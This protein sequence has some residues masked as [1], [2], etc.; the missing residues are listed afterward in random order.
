MPSDVIPRKM[1]HTV[2]GAFNDDD[3][4]YSPYFGQ[5][6]IQDAVPK[7]VL[8]NNSLLRPTPITLETIVEETSSLSGNSAASSVANPTVP[9]IEPLDLSG[10]ISPPECVS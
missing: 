1:P 2:I 7:R 4:G 3:D 9:V 5:E 6:N 8:R 10:L